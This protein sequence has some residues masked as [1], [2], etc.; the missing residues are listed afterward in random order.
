MRFSHEGV[1]HITDRLKQKNQKSVF[2]LTLLLL[3]YKG[4]E[5]GG[6]Q[7]LCAIRGRLPRFKLINQS[8]TLA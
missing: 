8:R 1:F 4:R 2:F 7:K 5:E 3:S 6:L